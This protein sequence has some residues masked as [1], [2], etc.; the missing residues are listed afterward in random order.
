MARNKHF[1]VDDLGEEARR[2]I[3]DGLERNEREQHIIDRVRQA[4]GETIARSSFNR[5]ASWYRQQQARR[6][7]IRER[8]EVAVETAVKHGSSMTEG[9]KAELL[10]AFYEAA[11]DGE[12][13]KTP[14]FFLGKLA[15]AF[16]ENDR[17]ERELKVREQQLELDRRKLEALEKK[18]LAADAAKAKAR[19][20]V[21]RA[22]DSISPKVREEILSIYGLDQ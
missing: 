5:Y 10:D 21:E 1:A 18:L 6:Q 7:E 4:T 14:P 13:A 3:R 8:V 20:V 17:K 19:E 12:L 22:G 16:A 15:V 9:V 11:R 2:I